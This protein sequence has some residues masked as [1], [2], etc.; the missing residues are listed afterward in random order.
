MATLS[1]L[2]AQRAALA[3]ALAS[4]VSRAVYQGRT[5]EYRS[6]AEMERVLARIDGE[7]ATLQ[8]ARPVRTIYVPGRKFL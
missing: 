7:I 4:G 8:S 5:V 6:I 3:T 1:D 2:Q